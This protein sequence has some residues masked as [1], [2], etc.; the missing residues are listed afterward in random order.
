MTCENENATATFGSLRDAFSA[1]KR[2]DAAQAPASGAGKVSAPAPA[3]GYGSLSSAIAASG[4][5]SPA[6]AAVGAAST[7]SLAAAVKASQCRSAGES[8]SQAT[9]PVAERFVSINGEGA[10][11]GKLAAFIRF[12]GCNLRCG[13]CDTMWAN[14]PGAAAQGETPQQLVAWVR[15]AGVECVTLTGGEPV[16]Q[17]LLPQLVERLLGE[18]G[19]GGCG[20]R[21]EIETNGAADLGELAALR[22]R[23]GGAAPGSLS[24]TVDWKLP[25]SGME[26]R[27]L[28]AN[29]SLLDARDTVKFVCGQGDLPRVLDVARQ[30][31]LPGRVPVYLSPCFGDIEPARIVEFMQENRMTWAT[32]QVQ[33][34]KVIWPDVERGV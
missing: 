24:F 27:M 1:F 20:L 18:P 21:V 12:T 19:P 2:A 16:L 25:S 5:Q 33:L 34:H 22:A 32:A 17:P 9:M 11:A 26:Q 28:P 8:G 14:A 6:S 3:A 15:Q 4:V 29:F 7:S 13:Y 31:D 30:L 23:I 10:C